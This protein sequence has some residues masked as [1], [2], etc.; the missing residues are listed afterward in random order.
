MYLDRLSHIQLSHEFLQPQMM[1]LDSQV[2]IAFSSHGNVG[3]WGFEC[4]GKN[5]CNW[6]S[7]EL[8]NSIL[9]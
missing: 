1:D 4:V 6:R 8:V 9:G 3:V 2:A 7:R 5:D